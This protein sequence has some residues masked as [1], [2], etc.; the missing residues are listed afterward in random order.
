M[1]E[2]ALDRITLSRPVQSV[3]ETADELDAKF[4]YSLMKK[5]VR[6]DHESLSTALT[7]L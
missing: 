1:H 2:V 7:L 6:L 4:L 5:H 3:V